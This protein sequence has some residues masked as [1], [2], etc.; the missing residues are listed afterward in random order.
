MFLPLRRT[1]RRNKGLKIQ[2]FGGQNAT[3][4]DAV[5]PSS[6]NKILKVKKHSS[7]KAGEE[8]K[9][10][11]TEAYM[12]LTTVSSLSSR[13]P[14]AQVWSNWE[15][16]LPVLRVYSVEKL[17]HARCLSSGWRNKVTHDFA[18]HQ[19]RSGACDGTA[20][21]QSH[22]WS[23]RGACG[24]NNVGLRVLLSATGKQCHGSETILAIANVH[25]RGISLAIPILLL[26]E[27]PVGFILES[28]LLLE[29]EI[30][31]LILRL[32]IAFLS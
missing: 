19:V 1:A 4:P 2:R 23:V 25:A 3:G 17:R 6:S 15:G 7:R 31:R 27:I 8:I 30:S 21:S 22:G 11:V 28:R 24:A 16:E 13:N 10:S 18:A 29:E 32:G 5:H 20:L 9:M 14:I 12:L 26:L